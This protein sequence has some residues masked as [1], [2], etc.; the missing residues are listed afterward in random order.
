M[1][2]ILRSLWRWRRL[3]A[4]LARREFRARYAGSAL[5]AA[6]A[7]LEPAVQFG[8]YLFVF[9]YFLGMRIE[10]NASVSSFGLYL[11]GGLVPYLALQEAVVRSASLARSNAALVRQVGLPLEVLLAGTLGAVVARHAVAFGL[12]V[13]A[14]AAMGSLVWSQ[15][16]WLAVGVALLLALALGLALALLPIGAFLPDVAPVVGTGTTVLF[17]LAPIVY[18]PSALPEA[19]GRYLYLNP[20]TGLADAFRAGIGL[21]PPAPRALAVTAAVALVSLAAGALVFERRAAAVR[22]LV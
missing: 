16:P 6:W 8:L 10:S 19:F 1:F 2:S 20:L 13:A 3:V 14:A 12:V 11:V 7:V 15:L 17:F 21:A 5:G 22:D 18:P 4:R 9:A